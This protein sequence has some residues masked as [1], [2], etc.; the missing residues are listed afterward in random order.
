MIFGRFLSLKES[1]A[2]IDGADTLKRFFYITLP[3]LKPATMVILIVSTMFALKAIGLIYVMT[4]G[5]PGNET[6]VLGWLIYS[7][8][9]KFLD[10]GSGA[11][12]SFILAFITLI[13]AWVYIKFLYKEVEF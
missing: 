12:V 3:L 2:K 6:T 5:G 7:E 1:L 9:F 4:S 8:A 10:F 11:A 13:V